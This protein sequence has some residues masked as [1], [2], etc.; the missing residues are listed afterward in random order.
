[1]EIMG[2]CIPT[3]LTSLETTYDASMWSN[4]YTRGLLAQRASTIKIKMIVFI[5][6]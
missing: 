1:M 5:Q 2:E 3:Y 4:V 6:K